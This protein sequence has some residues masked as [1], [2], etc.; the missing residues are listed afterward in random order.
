MDTIDCNLRT[1]VRVCCP[2]GIG[3]YVSFDEVDGAVAIGD[4]CVAN[5][6]DVCV[7]AQ[8]G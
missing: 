1:C 8:S 3:S 4:V 5:E 6:L 7:I 2:V